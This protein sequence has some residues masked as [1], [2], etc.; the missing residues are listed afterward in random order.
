V[1]LAVWLGVMALI[2]IGNLPVAAETVAA[3]P[4]SFEAIATAP[5]EIHCYWLAAKG[6]TGYRLQRDGQTLATLGA[7]AQEYAD[8]GLAPDS[9]H[10]YAV[11]ALQGETI[12]APREYVERTFS[13][14]PTAAA[15]HH[16]P[17]AYF[18]VVI[19]QASTGGVAAAIEAGKRGLK[20]ALVEPTTRLGGMPVNGLSAT[21]LRKPQYASGFFVRFRDRVKALYASE[22]I[23]TD[24][25][26]YE[27]RIAHQAMK[28]L[29][30]EA[31]NI[32][33]W[34]RM[35]L[36]SVQAVPSQVDSAR[37]RVES[38][39]VEE[40][41]AEGV[42]TGHH[43]QLNAKVFIDATDCGD[44]AAW[45]GAPYRIGREPRSSQEPHNGVIYYDRAHDKALPG[46]TGK[47]DKRIQAYAYL[48]V[49]KDYGPGVDKTLPQPPAGYRKEDFVHSPGWRDSWAFTSGAMPGSKYELNQHPQGGDIQAI[50][51]GYP[52][53]GYTERA[54]IEKLYRDHVLGYLYYIQT[55]LGQKSLGLP[56]DEYRDTGG[57]PP[58]LYV[59]EGRRILGE[60][61]PVEQ[62]ISDAR[63]I[64]RPES[65]GLGDYPMDSH[66]VRPKTDWSTPDMGEGEWWLYQHTPWHQLPLGI[67]VPQRLDNVFV[68]TAVSSTHV[69]FGTYRL[70]PVR[71]A[72][73]EAAA[74]AA[75][76]SIHTHRIGR[77]VPARQI[78]DE[79]LPHIANANA[80][81]AVQL[82]YFTDV[83]PGNPDYREIQYLAAHGFT[84]DAE[85]FQPNA[86]TT[87]AEMARWFTVLAQ[88]AP[89]YIENVKE[90]TALGAT[91]TQ[92]RR[93]FYAYMGAPADPQVL[94][95]LQNLPAPSTPITRADFALWLTRL[96]PDLAHTA[97][98]RRRRT[99]A[100]FFA[101]VSDRDARAAAII[102][103]ANHI[104]PTLWDNWDA[105]TTDGKLLLRPDAPL[106]HA[107]VFTALFLA[108]KALGP[109]FN[110]HPFDG[111][112]G[113]YVPEALYDHLPTTAPS[114]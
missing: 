11:Q 114:P 44:L 105:F 6:A 31:P 102:L 59:R 73:G 28:S 19:V 96:L 56:D 30:Y 32:T 75:A 2:G 85:T 57:F 69:S 35:R 111:R 33:V 98:P 72:F 103:Y 66:A 68:T 71:M 100:R 101:D 81:S 8:K 51:Y 107:Q 97:D 83:K 25:T 1:K 77:E 52:E 110:D 37:R 20:V 62:D 36:K 34:R 9:V 50:N 91:V 41:N 47:G 23:T 88:R 74:I 63:R 15:D 27:P 26:K 70:E 80:D 106:T 93:P 54:R 108:Q 82:S 76:I 79:M 40:L 86:P 104:D 12:S 113:R 5:T 112:N 14:F 10:R 16:T 58:L 95:S 3:A 61:L 94:R 29:L 7:E 60:Q 46:S 21:D 49:V 22:G 55:V 109:L 64:T 4:R 48:F 90:P 43:A 84:G 18:D 42:P 92:A 67:I 24:G 65:I 13:P 89:A 17:I 45:A 78:Q 99:A 87:R 38:V 53:A 39:E